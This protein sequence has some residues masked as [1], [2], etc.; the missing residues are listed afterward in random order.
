MSAN[1]GKVQVLGVRKLGGQK[2]RQLRLLQGRNGGW[3]QRP[4]AADYDASA[5]WL[6]ELRPAFGESRIF[7][8]EE[9]EQLYREKIAGSTADDFE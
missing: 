4:F 9:L 3:V 7:F 6:N 2:V 5:T 1:L 8:E